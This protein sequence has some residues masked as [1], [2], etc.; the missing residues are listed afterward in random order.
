MKIVDKLI[1]FALITMII[2]SL[3]LS[4]KIW[5]NSDNKQLTKKQNEVT[6]N[7]T[8]QKKPADVFLPVSLI[9]HDKAGKHLYSNKEG[10]LQSLTR[11]LLE[12]S[13]GDMV[14]TG[15]KIDPLKEKETFELTLPNELSLAYFLDINHKKVSDDV[16]GATKF[17]RLVV[18]LNEK[19]LCFVDNDYKEVY[20]MALKSDNQIFKKILADSANRF[21]EVVPR[22]TEQGLS[23]DF[24]DEIKL[25]KYSYILATQSYNVFSKAFFL[26]TADVISDKDDVES[27]DIKLV[28]SDGDAMDVIFESGEVI[29]KGRMINESSEKQHSTIFEN[30]FQYLKNLGNSLGSIRYYEG[31]D[32]KITYRNYVEGYPVFG[33]SSKGQINFSKNQKGIEIKLNQQTIQVPIP[34]DDKVE[35]PSTQT[36]ID[37]LNY[38]GIETEDI[39]GLQIGYTWLSNQETTQVVDLTPEWYIKLDNKWQSLDEVES[40]IKKEA[41]ANGF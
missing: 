16:K 2:I 39:Q 7:T 29:F 11:Q 30:S 27:T 37:T 33:D 13:N 9:Y 31:N 12:Q 34:S 36:V 18:S 25:P 23:Y 22:L 15:K 21:V 32:K 40:A 28:N 14:G 10:L 26:S 41:A 4:W 5:R 3:F 8:L 17:S 20:Q 24:S 19:K 1:R 35:I 38:Y 6:E